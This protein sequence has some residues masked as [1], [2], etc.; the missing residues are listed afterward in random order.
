MANG[1]AMTAFRKALAAPEDLFDV[2]TSFRSETGDLVTKVED[3]VWAHL[4]VDTADDVVIAE[5]L[6]FDEVVK[7]VRESDTVWEVTH[8]WKPARN[9]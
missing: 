8:N 2:G 1:R 9:V 7:I 3:N 4:A 5:T 6:G